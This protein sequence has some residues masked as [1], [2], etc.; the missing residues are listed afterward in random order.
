MKRKEMERALVIITEILR[1]ANITYS[2]QLKKSQEEMIA[3]F[4]ELWNLTHGESN[5]QES[6]EK[7]K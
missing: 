6:G 3:V 4:S 5:G 2:N 1:G 7:S